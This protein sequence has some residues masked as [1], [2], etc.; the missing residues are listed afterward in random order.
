VSHETFEI[1][2]DSA[3]ASVS[4]EDPRSELPRSA[5]VLGSTLAVVDQE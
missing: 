5:E 4:N 1:E 2:G 3:L